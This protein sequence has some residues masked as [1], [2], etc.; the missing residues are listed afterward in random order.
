VA[1]SDHELLVMKRMEVRE[2]L[3]ITNPNK[4][5]VV[6]KLDELGREWEAWLETVR[7]LPDSPDYNPQTCTEAIKDGFANRELHGVLRDKTL[8]FIGN[9][10]SGYAFLFANWSPFPHENSIGRLRDIV[11]DW[12]RR[13]KTLS[14]C[15]EYARVTDGFWKEK[16]K[17][18]TD[19]IIKA[20][21]RAAE[22]AATYLKNPMG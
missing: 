16:G 1:A 18:L 19:A 5:W 10:F 13:L 7:H 6:N 3:T 20:P 11:P 4:G 8:V 2:I 22:I 12:I 17:Q 15:I 21:D 14:E 9:H